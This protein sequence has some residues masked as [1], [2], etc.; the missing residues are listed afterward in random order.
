MSAPSVGYRL[1]GRRELGL[2]LGDNLHGVDA[3]EEVAEEVR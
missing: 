3:D 2:L 1:L